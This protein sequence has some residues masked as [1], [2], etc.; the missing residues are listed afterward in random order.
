MSG[1]ANS[2]V[3]AAPSSA[4]FKRLRQDEP[5][6]RCFQLRRRF[7]ADDRCSA[8]ERRLGAFLRRVR[9]T[10]QLSQQ[11]LAQLTAAEPWPLS[12]AEISALERG[13]H[14][15]RFEALYTLCR[16][17][18]LGP[19]RLIEVAAAALE[20]TSEPSR[21]PTSGF[22]LASAG[23]PTEAR[24]DRAEEALVQGMPWVARELAEGVYES[25]RDR[26]ETQMRA[27][28]ILA[29]AMLQLGRPALAGLLAECALA[30]DQAGDARESAALGLLLARAKLAAGD[31]LGAREVLLKVSRTVAA[32]GEKRM[33]SQL[34][35]LLGECDAKLGNSR[36][37]VAYLQRAIVTGRI[38][39]DLA[40]EA[41]WY[42]E[43]GRLRARAGQQDQAESCFARARHLTQRAGNPSLLF[44]AY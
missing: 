31:A 13:A 44:R 19:A 43:L 37:A 17:L 42:G 16:V 9:E 18:H 22:L 7:R 21:P 23:V 8:P 28:Q 1:D 38:A 24:L 2:T 40:L 4:V 36:R 3:D 33:A 41:L 35:G 32:S 39:K 30:R 34:Y 5:P 20:D 14:L 26:R 15:P 25:E 12:R 11:E 27:L 6:G 10:L 29:E